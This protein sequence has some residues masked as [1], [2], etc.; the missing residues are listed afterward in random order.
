MDEF[1]RRADPLYSDGD[2]AESFAEFLTRTARFMHDLR[3]RDF[4]LAFVF[5]HE[6]WIKGT[7]WQEMQ[8]TSTLD[9]ASMTAFHKFALSF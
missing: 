6:Q 9:T 3:G 4:E 5:T 8:L 2:Q 1:W 7:I